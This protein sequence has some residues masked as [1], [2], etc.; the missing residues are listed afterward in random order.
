MQPR[1]S[2][3]GPSSAA[4]LADCVELL[5]GGS[6]TFYAASLLLPRQ[7]RAS[8]CV[9]Y[10]F[11][12]LADDAVDLGECSA[13]A[14]AQL[15]ERLRRAYDGRPLA[16]AAD[17]AFA[18]VVARH[19]VPRALPEALLEGFEWDAAGRRYRDLAEL[20][21][22]AARVAGAV[23][24]MMAVLMGVRAAAPLARACDLGVAMQL[25]NIARDVGEDARAGR[26]YLPL[27]WLQEAGIDADAWL[28]CPTFSVALG[29]VV[30]R[31]LAAADELYE[32]ACPGIEELPLSCRP[33]IYAASFLYADI[34]H[35]VR[36]RGLD[37]VSSRAVVPATRKAW[38][39][40]RALA[41]SA[42]RG[43]HGHESPLAATG[44]LVE[45]VTVMGERP[46]AMSKPPRSP[47]W[48][49]DERAAWV[50]DLFERLERRE[51]LERGNL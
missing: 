4:D 24:A 42:N 32:R 22:Y 40:T 49:L 20:Q 8:A 50:I 14:L 13:E 29:S 7:V 43:A 30:Q 38:H 11:C 9:L 45:A 25:S 6:R 39:L 27:E 18:H 33:A 36:R 35:E 26:L 37:S 1:W 48:S 46:L 16:L 10:A 21:A 51:Q 44:F 3:S 19:Q 28:K 2:E 15:R 41:A 12:R 23:G 34:G 47:R 17:R 5:K 31:L